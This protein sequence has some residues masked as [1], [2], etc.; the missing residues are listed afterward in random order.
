LSARLNQTARGKQTKSRQQKPLEDGRDPG[1]QRR[2]AWHGGVGPVSPELEVQPF[3]R[4][5]LPDA[6]DWRDAP[7]HLPR[8][9]ERPGATGHRRGCRRAQPLAS[10]A[11]GVGQSASLLGLGVGDAQLRPEGGELAREALEGL[12]RRCGAPLL[13]HAAYVAAHHQLRQVSGRL[14]TDETHERPM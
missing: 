14:G 11:H 6:E 4:H 9:V 12:H 2:Q 8:R 7:L 3:E 10:D 5:G 1:P 13:H